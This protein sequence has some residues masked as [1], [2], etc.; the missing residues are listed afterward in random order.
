MAIKRNT[1][2]IN[3]VAEFFGVHR[4]TI[5]DWMKKDPDFPKGF[6]KFSTVRFRREE[7]EEYWRK[8]PYIPPEE[9][10]AWEGEI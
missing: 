8:N 3:E 1:M 6:R 4:K 5:Y 7:I 10:L 9:D 2:T